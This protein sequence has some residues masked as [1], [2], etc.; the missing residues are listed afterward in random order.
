MV[1]VIS[2][3]CFLN[4]VHLATCYEENE[5]K[6]SQIADLEETL[7]DTRQQLSERDSTIMELEGTLV[8]IYYNFII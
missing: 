3:L 6:G 8:C 1:K 4:C 5:M 7:R 2:D